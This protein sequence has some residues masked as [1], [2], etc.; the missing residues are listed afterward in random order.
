MTSQEALAAAAEFL[1]GIYPKAPPTIVLRPDWVIEH[2]WA[3][4]VLFD[5]QEHLE[6][7][8]FMQALLVRSVVVPKDGSRV[9][10]MPS[11]FSHEAQQGYLA[12]GE[13]PNSETGY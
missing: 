2:S 12:T 9:D 3:W 13:W 11:A 10:F 7:G 4:Q 5:T 1:K 6:S 8:D